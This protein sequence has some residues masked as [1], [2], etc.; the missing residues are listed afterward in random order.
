[1]SASRYALKKIGGEDWEPEMLRRIELSILAGV[2]ILVL[3]APLF[4]SRYYTNILISAFI[5]AMFAISVDL[6][7]GYAGILTFGHAAFFGLGAYVMALLTSELGG[8]GIVYLGILGG[9]VLPGIVGLV[10]AG[11][12]FYRG[13]D[14]ESFT[15]IT[16][17]VAIIANQVAASWRSVTGGEN[18]ILGIAHLEIGVPGVYMYPMTGNSLYYAMLVALIGLYFLAKRIIASPFGKAIVAIKENERKARALGYK[19][20]LYK[21]L[22]FGISSAIAGLAGAFYATYIRFVS[23]P[24]LG[25]IQST[26]VLIWVIIGGRGTLIGPVIGTV[27]LVLG[28]NLLRGAFMLSW[29]LLLGVLLIV[30]V[31]AAPEGLIGRVMEIRTKLWEQSREEE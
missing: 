4:T 24:L 1:M 20:R 7:W 23:P 19:T 9:I 16:L 13:I 17:A 12:L 18:G 10:I 15:I 3:I 30:V 14:K 27:F 21:T 6:V 28:E 31:I 22:I 11:I 25:F 29:M 5:F 8:G 26:E 2:T